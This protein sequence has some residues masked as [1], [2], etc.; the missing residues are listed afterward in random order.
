M[1]RP[2]M[3][4]RIILGFVLLVLILSLSSIIAVFE[5]RRMSNYVSGMIA[6]N[7]KC[8]NTAHKLLSSCDN[9]NM[10]LLTA[11]SDDSV[12]TLPAFDQN[13]FSED[14]D[15]LRQAVT[16][17]SAMMMVDSV[18]YAYSAYLLVAGE[19]E[20]V[21]LADFSD[22][23]TRDWYFNRLQP[24]Y[25]RLK[26][27]IDRLS[28]YSYNALQT[29]SVALQESFYRSIM[30][31]MIAVMVGI[32]ISFLFM[33]FII[34]RYVT[35][36]RKMLSNIHDYERFD[37]TYSYTFDGGDELSALND[38]IKDII[39]QNISLKRHYNSSKGEDW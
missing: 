23:N 1:S 29:N 18:R 12:E 3:R 11:I 9:Y 38:D 34:S 25:Y 21:W 14:Y 39:E 37:K 15:Y 20:Q 2:G 32:L 6:E 30:P 24:I 4:G 10:T 26:D 13:Q 36:V 22:S 19:M 35:P 31:G 28:D 7:I 8:I 17:R 16:G 27:Y 33:Y 5:Y